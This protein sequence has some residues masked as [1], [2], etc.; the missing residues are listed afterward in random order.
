MPPGRDLLLEIDLQGAQQIKRRFPDSVVIL[1]VPPSATAQA[2][3]LR[4]RGDDEVAIARRLALGRDEVALGTTIADHQ[5]VN[6]DLDRTLAEVA[7]IPPGRSPV[8][9]QARPRRASTLWEDP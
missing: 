9:E 6:E 7:G 1:L 2:A 5:V 3:R 4:Q 8:E